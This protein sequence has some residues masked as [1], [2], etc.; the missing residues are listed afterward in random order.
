MIVCHSIITSDEVLTPQSFSR[1]GLK[2][3]KFGL[4]FS[5]GT[6]TGGLGLDL[7]S[8]GLGHCFGLEVPLFLRSSLGFQF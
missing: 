1:D 3:A 7:V 8:P 5:L 2:T 4:F 6:G